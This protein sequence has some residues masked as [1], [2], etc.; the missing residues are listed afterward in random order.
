MKL[1]GLS[2]IASFFFYLMCVIFFV[3]TK[4]C[5]AQTDDKFYI[6]FTDKNNSPF[7]I[8][9]PNSY[10]SQKSIE[11]RAKQNI[12]I[13]ETDLPVNPEYLNKIRQLGATV[14]YPLK[15]LNGAIVQTSSTQVL[16]S[17]YNLQF[18]SFGKSVNKIKPP[19]KLEDHFELLPEG[20]QST[21]T[22]PYGNSLNQ[23]EMLNGI[24]LH[25]Q[26]FTGNTI[27]IAVLDAGFA[28]SN[29]HTAFDSLRLNNRLIGTKDFTFL[30]PA[31]VFDAS[32]SGHGTAVL[33]TMA[34]YSPGNLVG[35]APHAN[36]WLIR[37]EYAPS[38]YL[39][40]EYNWVAA[41]E[42]VD[43]AGADIINSSL[44]YSTFDDALQNHTMQELDGRTSVCS[45]AA[46]FCSRKGI[47]VC[48]SAGN[49]GGSSWPKI[50][51]PAD[52]DSILTVGAVDANQT[53]AGF[54]SVGPTQD[55]RIKPDVM[56]Q[57]YASVVTNSNGAIGT[58]SGTSFSS[59]ILAGMVACL[60]QA[61][62]TKKNMEII[63]AI[64]QSATFA[65]SPNN[66]YGYGI[67]DF[68]KANQLLKGLVEIDLGNEIVFYNSN[69]FSE[70]CTVY[71]PK[72]IKNAYIE[73]HD[74]NGKL[75]FNEYFTQTINSNYLKEL[76]ML[77]AADG[78][79]ILK[80][81]DD[82]THSNLL[83]SKKIV[84]IN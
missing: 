82:A 11:R 16:D 62:P 9:Q 35:T 83:F 78:I 21:T 23:I 8:Q 32:T 4:N 43:S 2:I 71:F 46:L 29:L 66:Q 13:N 67:P 52:A 3:E 17:I 53:I 84:K 22:L 58:S 36:Y 48:S 79:Y 6:Q 80:V 38:E 56:A 1:Q 27:S 34:G 18:V 64:K 81:Y 14:L 15:W 77:Q 59:P 12:T 25:E 49:S 42:F 44:G 75:L 45:K 26:G 55:G 70:K 10:L 30:P 73:I 76:N 63:N 28:K 5:N 33:G 31:D 20:K 50:G 24:C 57:G 37:C 61:N 65:D 60:W 72:E 7:S 54:S 39:I 19:K 41:A 47:I 68:C 74:L 69:P 40:E 51:F